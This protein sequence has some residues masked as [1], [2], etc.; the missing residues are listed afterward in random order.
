MSHTMSHTIYLGVFSVVNRIFVSLCHLQLVVIFHIL[1]ASFSFTKNNQPE[2][3]ITDYF[4]FTCGYSTSSLLSCSVI[5]HP[6]TVKNNIIKTTKSN[7]IFSLI[8]NRKSDQPE[9]IKILKSYWAIVL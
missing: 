7:C 9:V 3:Q 5:N 8:I 2:V 4:P 6:K 1:L